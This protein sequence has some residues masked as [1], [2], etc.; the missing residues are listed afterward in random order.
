M[1]SK[2]HVTKFGING[3]TLTSIFVVRSLRNAIFS[4]EFEKWL[5]D[6]V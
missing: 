4:N 1:R 2:W 5:R 3:L 6:E